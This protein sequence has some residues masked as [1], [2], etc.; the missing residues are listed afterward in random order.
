MTNNLAI[1]GN[2]TK[3]L[4]IIKKE[5]LSKPFDFLQKIMENK[6]FFLNKS[7]KSISDLDEEDVLSDRMN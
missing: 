2:P 1:S 5:D 7:L 6:K 3:A 4:K